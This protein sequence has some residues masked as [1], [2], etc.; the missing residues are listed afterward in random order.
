M[1]SF[2]KKIWYGSHRVAIVLLPLAWLFRALVTIRS[3]L[4][5][6]RWLRSRRLSVPAVIVGNLTV[7]GTGKTPLT[8]WLSQR[9]RR[10]GF[11][12]G[13]LS[14]GY[15]G[16]SS[17]WPLP[18]TLNSDPALV[19]DEAL[20]LARRSGCR[21]AVGPDRAAAAQL[22]IKEGVNI[23]ICDDGLQH[24]RLARDFEILVIDG[25]LGFGN[26]HCLP[27]GPLREPV[28]RA[29]MVDV[30]VQNGGSEP[31]K[32]PGKAPCLTMRLRQL[33]AVP[34]LGGE[35]RRL[36]DF[37]GSPVHAVAGIGNPERFFRQLESLGLE[38]IRHPKPDHAALTM[39]DILFTDHY[40]VLMTEKDAVKC[41]EFADQ[42]HF[43]VPVTAE[44]RENDAQ[45]LIDALKQA[46]AAVGSRPHDAGRIEP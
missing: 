43:F 4:Y 11:V 21:V 16:T 39:D 32:V 12:P 25:E 8:I 14:R 24:L 42:R 20:V 13:I 3:A 38:V 33:V 10:E 9:L 41:T 45:L 7:G 36:A 23:V 5:R 35:N 30:V 44:L 34:M 15:R 27:A 2:A 22:L 29:S 40:P 6:R 37:A 46:L 26:G 28:A 19:G 18:V 31:I 1:D 17:E